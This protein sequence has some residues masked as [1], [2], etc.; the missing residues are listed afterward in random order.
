MRRL[1]G[2]AVALVLFLGA[3]SSRSEMPD[4]RLPMLS[5]K[6]G[7][8]L[9]SCAAAKCLT[10]YVA[11]WCGYCRQATPQILRLRDFLKERGILTRVVVG[12]D[13]REALIDN[14]RDFGPETLIDVEDSFDVRGVPHFFVSDGSGRVL[15]EVAGVP[16]GV[17]DIGRF[18]AYFGLP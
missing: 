7:V 15:K 14:A 1:T 10:V 18:A 3:C 16:T 13:R 12:K 11:P 5:G 4:V 17:D 8:N 2:P 9:A 6:L